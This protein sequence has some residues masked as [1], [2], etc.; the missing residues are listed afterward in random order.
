MV[1]SAKIPTH[2]LPPRL[3]PTPTISIRVHMDTFR[4]VDRARLPGE[5]WDLFIRRIYDH[6]KRNHPPLR[7][8]ERKEA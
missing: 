5:S 7:R 6:W 3:R 4:E 8:R 1:T 2:K